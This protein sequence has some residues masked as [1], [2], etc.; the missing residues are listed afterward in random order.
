MSKGKWRG[1]DKESGDVD[2]GAWAHGNCS[3]DEKKAT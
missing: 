1:G 3:A 2:K